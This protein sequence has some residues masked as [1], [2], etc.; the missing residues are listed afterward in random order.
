M[1][2]AISTLSLRVKVLIAVLITLLMD[3]VIIGRVMDITIRPTAMTLLNVTFGLLVIGTAAMIYGA[4]KCSNSYTTE[5]IAGIS[6][7]TATVLFMLVCVALDA[8]WL[9]V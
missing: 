6:I 8:G 5:W 4:R 1:K 7:G 9:T 2:A 3:E